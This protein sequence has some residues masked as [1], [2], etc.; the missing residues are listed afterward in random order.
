MAKLFSF[1]F[2]NTIARFILRNRLLILIAVIGA[3]VFLGSQWKHMQFSFTEANLLPDDHPINI[4][5]NKFLDK[6]GEEGN[7]I[8]IATN[9]STLFTP[10]KLSLIHI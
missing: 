6:F 10:K 7:L 9:D 3:T 5:Y 8:V 4:E 1:G 2:W